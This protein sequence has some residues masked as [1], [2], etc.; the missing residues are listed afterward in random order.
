MVFHICPACESFS[1]DMRTDF[2]RLWRWLE[3][4]KINPAG[5]SVEQTD[6][7]EHKPCFDKPFHAS[8]HAS[9]EDI[10][11][12]IDQVDLDYIVP[13]HTEERE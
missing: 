5:F 11:W 4:F 10:A 8:G 12:V 2:L 3:G 1:D 6:G 7:G 13:I 9:R